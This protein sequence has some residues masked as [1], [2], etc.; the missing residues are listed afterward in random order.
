MEEI[1]SIEVQEVTNAEQP[2]TGS[3]EATSVSKFKSG[4]DRDRAYA[5]L[6]REFTRRSQRLRELELENES[7]KAPDPVQEEVE[8]FLKEFP[9]AAKAADSIAE[10][11]AQQDADSPDALLRAYLKVLTAQQN[12]QELIRDEEF[13]YRCAVENPAVKER[14]VRQYLSTLGREEPVRLHTGG[15]VPLSPAKRPKDI[16]EAGTMAQKMLE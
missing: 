10:A 16:Q 8:A 11:L 2:G 3:A 15:T 6:E 9:E 12:S 7:L 5:E 1:Y 4:Q 13:V 14:V